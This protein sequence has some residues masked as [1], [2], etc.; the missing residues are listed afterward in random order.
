M[1]RLFRAVAAESGSHGQSPSLLWDVVP[2]AGFCAIDLVLFSHFME[3]RNAPLDSS[4]SRAAVVGYAVFGFAPLLLRR[5][6]PLPVFAIVYVHA[7]AA[8]QLPLLGYTPMLGLLVALYTVAVVCGPVSNLVTLLASFVPQGLVVAG[9]VRS[10]ADNHTATL[11]A[12]SV[13]SALLTITVWGIG[14]WV[15]ASRRHARDLECRRQVAAREA[16]AAE[17]Q[18]IARELHDIV[19]HSVTVMVL[20]AGG[21]QQVLH[22]NPA[23]VGEAL[24][25]IEELGK[26]AMVELRRLLVVLRA[27]DAEDR[28][29]SDDT[30]QPGLA[31]LDD[32]LRTFRVAGL[33]IHL[34][35]RGREQPLDRSVDLGA[36]RIIQEALTNVMKHAGPGTPTT[37]E[38]EWTD[39]LL[40]RITDHGG[41]T[42]HPA[43]RNLSTGHGLLGLQE[44]VS[45]IGGSVRAAPA[46]EGFQVTALL[47]TQESTARNAGADEGSSPT[48][49]RQP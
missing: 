23:R 10:A 29:V 14:R 15:G 24:T 41:R 47:P 8:S 31:G 2:A 22:V 9:A 21:A 7:V 25:R 13:F 30:H 6:Y 12:N 45:V 26:Q 11:V 3:P 33:P 28:T 1:P 35:M 4:V 36:Y 38:L 32:L 39:D 5:R 46:G 43:A 20:Q 49:G 19:A 42:P 40:I 44:R 18:R 34:T 16:V 48:P 37:V 27:A 17:R